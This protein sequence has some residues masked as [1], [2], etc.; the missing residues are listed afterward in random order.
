MT[1]YGLGVYLQNSLGVAVLA[2]SDYTVPYQ[3]LLLDPAPAVDWPAAPGQ[4]THSVSFTLYFNRI[5]TPGSTVDVGFQRSAGG[6]WKSPFSRVVQDCWLR[7][8][9]RPLHLP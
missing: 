4:L 9:S 7:T 2:P 3:P 1:L 5:L 6:P 8:P